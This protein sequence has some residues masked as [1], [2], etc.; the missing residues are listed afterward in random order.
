MY[1]TQNQFHCH[2]WLPDLFDSTGGIQRYSSFCVRAFQSVYPDFNYDIF[3]KHDIH[4]PLV[5]PYL[6]FH[7]SGHLPL[8]LRTPAFAAQLLGFGLWQRPNLIFSTHLNFSVA[9]YQLKQVTNIPYCTIA[10]GIEAWDIKSSSIKTAL[11]HA[12]LILAVSNYTRDRLLKEQNLDPHK[13]ALLPNTFD[14]SRF[15]PASKP[16]YLLAQ[17]KLTPQQPV[18]LTV[19][20][21]AKGEQYKGYDKVLQALPLIRKVIPDIHYIIIGKGDDRS[22]IEQIIAQLELQG[23]VTLAGFVPDEHLCD[24]YNLCDV[25]AMP[26][27]G[28]GF[29][30]VYLEALACGKPVLAGNQDGA[31]DALC[32]GELGAL[33]NPEDIGEITQALL[34]ILRYVY[35]NPLIYQPEALRQKVITTFG[36]ERFQQNL[37]NLMGEHFKLMTRR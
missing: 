20:R 21:L 9:A 28:E 31:I 26:S 37:A 5:S 11:H 6:R 17:Y 14:A 15:K 4:L 13:V 3:I 1:S 7:G 27:K 34:K 33:V 23:C 16:A 2:L 24:Y 10:H 30:I 25:Y 8:S 12:D 32:H 29:G 22:R 36:F 35:P 18:I 19:A